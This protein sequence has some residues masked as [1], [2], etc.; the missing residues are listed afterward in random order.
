MKDGE[1]GVEVVGNWTFIQE[2]IGANT[3]GERGT[4]TLRPTPEVFC[5]RPGLDTR[6][7]HT[8]PETFLDERSS[9]EPEE[10]Q[11]PETSTLSATVTLHS[12][13]VQRESVWLGGVEKEEVN[14][15][16]VGQKKRK[17]GGEETT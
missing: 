14:E 9:R 5:P 1:R 7:C 8:C 4:T 11:S 6:V 15:R 10:V 12:G 13:G 17:K 3:R 2:A 16:R